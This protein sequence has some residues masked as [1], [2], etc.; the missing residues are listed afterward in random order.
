MTTSTQ[1]IQNS[2]AAF[3]TATLLITGTCIGGGMLALPVQTAESG[4]IL[5]F[6]NLLISWAFMAFTGLLLLEATLW[7]KQDC[8]FSSLSRIL[9]GHGMKILALVVYLFMNYASL[10]AYVAGGAELMRQWVHLGLNLEMSYS[11]SCVLFSMFFGFILFLGGKIVGKMNFIFVIGLAFCYLALVSFGSSSVHFSHLIFKPAYKETIGSIPLILATFSYQMVVPSVCSMMNYEAKSLKKVILYGTAIPCI[12]YMLWLFIVH[13]VVPYE[14]VHGLKQAYLD[15]HSATVS[16]RHM[17]GSK[18]LAAVADLFG[19]LAVVTSYLGLSLALF[20]FL[21]DCFK[22]LKIS[23]SLNTVILLTIIPALILAIL[24]PRALLQCLDIS[25][26]YGDTILAGLIPVF[27]VYVGRYKKNL[28]SDYKA[29]FG[30]PGL[31]LTGAFFLAI[32]IKEIVR[33]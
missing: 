25:G 18:L 1:I 27:M 28:Q 2:K 5:S 13:G 9:L 30:K 29:P 32:L 4:F 20:D 6:F 14:G 22:E 19:F 24:F 31:I 33:F 17:L 26:G 12:I 3:W 15:G 23:M 7:V 8:H 16:L 21:K 11:V 10:V